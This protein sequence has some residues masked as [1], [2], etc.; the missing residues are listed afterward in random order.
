MQSVKALL[1]NHTEPEEAKSDNAP[2]LDIV[3]ILPTEGMGSEEEGEK[4][5]REEENEDTGLCASCI[6]T[7]IRRKIVRTPVERTKYPFEL[8]HSDLCGPVTPPSMGGA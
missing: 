3:N 6:K 4:G 7:K 8:I 1:K 2:I 5:S